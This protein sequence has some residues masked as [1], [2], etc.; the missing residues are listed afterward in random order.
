MASNKPASVNQEVHDGTNKCF[1]GRLNVYADVKNP[2]YL[3]I[4]TFL[5]IK[6][7]A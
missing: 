5:A 4:E 1:N 3:L 7:P 2:F 6:I